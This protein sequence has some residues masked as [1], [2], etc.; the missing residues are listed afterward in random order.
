MREPRWR[1]NQLLWHYFHLTS[2]TPSSHTLHL[3]PS[4]L[5]PC[6]ESRESKDEHGGQGEQAYIM[7]FKKKKESEGDKTGRAAYIMV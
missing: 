4:R 2:A 5:S 7:V 1:R 6:A 3:A